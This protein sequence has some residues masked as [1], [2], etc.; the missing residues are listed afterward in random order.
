AT[1]PCVSPNVP[2]CFLQREQW[3][4]FAR[5]KGNVTSKVT[6][7]QRQLP[8]TESAIPT[9]LHFARCVGADLHDADPEDPDRLP[10]PGRLLGHQGRAE[11]AGA[12]APP[13]AARA[14][15]ARPASVGGTP[16][17]AASPFPRWA[18]HA[19]RSDARD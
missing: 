14:A 19:A 15:T 4:W 5:R 11:A 1:R 2:E 3:Q 16:P 9:K 6:P 18:A 12:G 17:A 13:G 8:R 7:P 10:L